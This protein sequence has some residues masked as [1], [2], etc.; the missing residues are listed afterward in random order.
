MKTASPNMAL[1][2]VICTS[3]TNS[4]NVLTISAGTS[5]CTL[6]T[7][8]PF[9][10][11]PEEMTSSTLLKKLSLGPKSP[12]KYSIKK[13]STVSFLSPMKLIISKKSERSKEEI[14]PK[15]REIESAKSPNFSGLQVRKFR[16]E[17]NKNRYSLSRD[18]EDSENSAVSA[19]KKVFKPLRKMT[20]SN[21]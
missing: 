20:G 8:L 4:Q 5:F 7:K 6:S 17:V 1:I 9:D 13:I 15:G 12:R 21:V 10:T 2:C 19:G 3:V 16:K 18:S 11:S 14:R